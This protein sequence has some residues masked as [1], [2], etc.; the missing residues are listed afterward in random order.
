[1]VGNELERSRT[2]STEA[3]EIGAHST[4]TEIVSTIPYLMVAA[5]WV[6]QTSINTFRQQ[7]HILPAT[8]VRD[9]KQYVGLLLKRD[10]CQ[11][12]SASNH[13]ISD[14]LDSKKMLNGLNCPI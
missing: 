12:E 6:D 10:G 5:N 2:M 14:F 4:I 3:V 11:R 9:M 8:L 7:P 1:M 13:R